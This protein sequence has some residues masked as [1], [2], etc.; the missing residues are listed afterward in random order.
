MYTEQKERSDSSENV[1][2]ARGRSDKVGD[3]SRVEPAGDGPQQCVPCEV[4]EGLPRVPRDIWSYYVS[5]EGGHQMLVLDRRPGERLRI[6]GTTD[7]VVLAIRN[8]QV[9]LR[10]EHVPHI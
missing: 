9:E 2:D 3:A 4:L 10:V 8:G 7:V 5:R 6:N 1:A